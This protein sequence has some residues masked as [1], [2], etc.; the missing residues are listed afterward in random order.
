[1]LKDGKQTEITTGKARSKGFKPLPNEREVPT[2][3]NNMKNKGFAPNNPN[4]PKDAR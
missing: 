1:M 3:P 4:I 2:P